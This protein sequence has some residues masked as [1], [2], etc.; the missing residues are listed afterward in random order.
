MFLQENCKYLLYSNKRII[1]VGCYWWNAFVA[2]KIISVLYWSF[3]LHDQ[4]KPSFKV[5]AVFADRSGFCKLK[6]HGSDCEILQGDWKIE[7]RLATFV[8]VILQEKLFH[9]SFK[10]DLHRGY[11][12]AAFLPKM[13]KLLY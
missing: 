12:F 7:G 9:A 5:C 4:C 13:C 8:L 2:V 3:V 6:S 1:H 10:L 11:S